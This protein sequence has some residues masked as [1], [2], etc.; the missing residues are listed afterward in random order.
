MLGTSGRAGNEF[1]G[2]RVTVM[3]LGRFGGQLGVIRWLAKQGA[4]VLVT[5]QAP[6]TQLAE[7]VAAL[8]GLPVR[9]RLGGHDENDFRKTDLLVVSPAVKPDAPLVRAA[10]D[11]DVPVTTEINLFIERCPAPCIGITGTV[12]K[13]TTT[14]MIGAI[15][16]RGLPAGR[17]WVGGNLGGSLL[18]QLTEI[19]P[20]DWVVLELSSFQLERL[21]PLR[22]SPQIAVY[23]PIAP[24]HLDWHG[25]FN[26]YFAAKLNL[27][28]FQDPARDTIVCPDTPMMRDH[29]ELMFGDLAGI[30]RYGVRDAAPVAVIQEQS[31]VDFDSRWLRWDDVRLRVPGNH[32]LL[33]AAAALSVANVLKISEEHAREALAEFPGLPHRLEAVATKA[34]VEYFNDSKSSTPDATRTALAAFSRPVVLIAG[35]YDKQIDLAPLTAELA[36]RC[37]FV[38]CI[39]Q[40]GPV[41]RAG[42]ST[43]GGDA[44]VFETLEQATATCAARAEPGDVVLLSPACASWGMFTNFEERGRAFAAAVAALPDV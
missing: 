35:G 42:I 15:L 44:E 12:G 31:S 37:K 1:A 24:N 26:A 5:D 10:G 20:G 4:D 14:A 36:Q 18:N 19:D 39:G 23:T 29:F 2:R 11:A 43:A 22:W 30:Y 34:G 3:G 32:N 40:T 6:A 21:A 7:S 16:Q 25:T 28:R 33:N 9:W 41:I 8:D 13:S 27:M 38:A 17:T